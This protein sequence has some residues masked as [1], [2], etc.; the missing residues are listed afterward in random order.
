MAKKKKSS[1]KYKKKS[2]PTMHHRNELDRLTEGTIYARN[3]TTPILSDINP[4]RLIFS[5]SSGSAPKK[6][7]KKKKVCFNF[8][9]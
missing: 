7:W 1:V 9:Y 8:W 2:L 5:N 6:G 3:K 4:L